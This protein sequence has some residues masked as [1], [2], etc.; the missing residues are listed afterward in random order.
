MKKLGEFLTPLITSN[1]KF[2]TLSTKFFFN[3]KVR[4]QQT[5]D[6]TCNTSIDNQ[7]DTC[8]KSEIV[9]GRRGYTYFI[10]SKK[11]ICYGVDPNLEVFESFLQVKIIFFFNL[12]FC[13]YY[14]FSFSNAC[15][16]VLKQPI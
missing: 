11:I 6:I 4:L 3:G 12:E 10:D 15:Q 14:C 9:D 7:Y 5:Y 1:S 8:Q 13:R 16:C 2:L